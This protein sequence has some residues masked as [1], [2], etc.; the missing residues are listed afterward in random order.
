VLR[1]AAERPIPPVGPGRARILI[2]SADRWPRALLRAELR[3]AGYDAIGASSLSRALRYP[4]D[5]AERGPVRLVVV[6]SATA[7]AE[8]VAL[9]RAPQRYPGV[10]FVLIRGAGAAS[11]G[12]WAAILQ[13]PLSIGDIVAAVRRLVPLSPGAV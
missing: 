2:V 11:R 5:D 7:A 10:P 3:D 8:P 13:R 12:P 1:R 9:E 4:P 6:D